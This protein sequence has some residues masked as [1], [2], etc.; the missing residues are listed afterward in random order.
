M[1]GSIA[2]FWC[3]GHNQKHSKF[4]IFLYN[5]SLSFP[6]ITL[7]TAGSR[8]LPTLRTLLHEIVQKI[9]GP[10]I[11]GPTAPALRPWTFSLLDKK[12]CL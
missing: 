12:K 1:G 6:K 5:N 11:A 9:I 8:E 2:K 7:W 10:A 4:I 3:L